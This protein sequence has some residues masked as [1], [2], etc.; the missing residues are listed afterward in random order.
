VSRYDP[1]PKQR[2]SASLEGQGL[3]SNQP[4]TFLSVG[5]DAVRELPMGPYPRSEH[6]VDWFHVT[7]RLT[8]MSRMAGGVGEADQSELSADLEEILEYLKW[9]LWYGKVARALEILDELGY[10]LDFENGSPEHRKLLKAVR[11]RR[12]YHGP[13]EP[14]FPIT[15]AQ[16]EGANHLDG[17]RGVG[18]QP[19]GQQTVVKKQ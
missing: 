14:S 1:E 18:R 9:N 10:I 15:G 4:V 8:V 2:L 12:L 16:P 17:V 13:T 19:G 11:P 3:Q 6:L 7:M 5:G